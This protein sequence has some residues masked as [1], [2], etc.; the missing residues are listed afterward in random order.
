MERE[1][2]AKPQLTPQDRLH[3]SDEQYLPLWRLAHQ[4]RVLETK[5]VAFVD[6]KYELPHST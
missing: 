5:H 1:P 6:A 2:T 4:N 3:E